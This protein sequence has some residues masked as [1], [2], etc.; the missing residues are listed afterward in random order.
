MI[1]LV[2]TDIDGTLVKDSTPDLY[3]E[4]KEMIRTLTAKGV[5]FVAA[6]GRGYHSMRQLFGEV[7]DDIIY[8]A[9]NGAVIIYKGK[10]ISTLTLPDSF[11]DMLILD[12]RKYKAGSGE[13]GIPEELRNCELSAST[14]EINYLESQNQE[15]ID[16]IRFGYRNRLEVTED[17]LEEER[18][19]VKVSLY[20]KEGIDPVAE[21]LVPEWKT[22]L[23]V[24]KAGKEWLDFMA[25]G[26]DKGNALHYIQSSLRIFSNETIAFG[27]NENDVGLMKAAGRSFAVPN[28]VPS[29][30]AASTDSCPGYAEKGVYHVLCDLMKEGCFNPYTR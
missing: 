29:V 9:A 4:M 13:A 10:V 25:R 5:Y 8:I 24:T 23:K 12:C 28:A 18:P 16:L 17:L 20:R 15:Y 14:A 11:F 7:A 27:D 21:K 22:F 2:A 26:V 19:Y 30:K 3:D 1:R 6:S